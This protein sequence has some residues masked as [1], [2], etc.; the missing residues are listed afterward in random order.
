MDDCIFCKIGRREI[1]VKAV[2]TN[3]T[4]VAFLDINPVSPGHTV[5]VPKK[6]FATVLDMDDAALG[7]LFSLVKEATAKIKSGLRCDGFNIGLNQEKAGGQA[8]PHVHV[9]V[10]PRFSGDGGGS[11]H[12]IVR[13]PPKETIDVI[14]NKIK[15]AGPQE[16]KEEKEEKIE[17][18]EMPK[19]KD[20]KGGI[21]KDWELD[22]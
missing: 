6:H 12:S 21:P 14:Y 16:A 11:M 9:H 3:D 22:L 10:I 17:L 15:N 5:A 20:I 1:P 2:A 4:A 18:P 8:I 7:S 19:M 13:N